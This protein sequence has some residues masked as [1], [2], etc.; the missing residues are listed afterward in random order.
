MKSMKC[1]AI[2]IVVENYAWKN[3]IQGYYQL[4]GHEPK[5]YETIGSVAGLFLKI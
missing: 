2:K 3:V 4:N 1:T 5:S